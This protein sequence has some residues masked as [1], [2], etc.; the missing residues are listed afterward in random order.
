MRNPSAEHRT[1]AQVRRGGTRGACLMGWALAL[2]LCA[3][4]AAVAVPAAALPP[5]PDPVP[6][7]WQLDVDPGPLRV[8]TVQTQDATT[9]RTVPRSYYVMTFTVTN[10]TGAD[11]QFAA[12]FELA[13]DQGTLVRSGRGVPQAVV[14]RILD[15]M[16]DPLLE[17]QMNLLGTLLQG[18]ENAR[19]G[20]VV[21]P[22]DRLKVSEVVVHAMGFSG[23]TK[24]YE[25]RAEDGSVVESFVLRKTLML[26]HA[27]GGE[28]DP[29]SDEPLA[30]TERRW[31]MRKSQS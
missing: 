25:V 18:K 31:I 5:Q 21:W 15:Q 11:V 19:T 9:G 1:R 26:R 4:S 14:E 22:A 8:M 2:G 16:R 17:P 30:R 29:T 7:R 10:N 27:V 3:F 24:P 12:S 20:L 6:R 23:E 13:D 28:L